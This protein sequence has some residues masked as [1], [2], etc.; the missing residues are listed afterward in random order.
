MDLKQK[1]I[2]FY[3][4][5]AQ[6]AAML[7]TAVRLK[8]GAIIVKNNSIS[9]F[10][11]NGTPAGWDNM[12]ETKEYMKIDAAGW[13]DPAEIEEMYP[14]KEY[15][16]AVESHRRYKLVTKQET[17]HAEMNAL[18]KLTKNGGGSDG[19]IMFVTHAPCI[20][21]AKAIYQ[22]G[23]KEVHYVHEYRETSGVDFLTTAGIKVQK[24]GDSE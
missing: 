9:S 7:S 19:A 5:V 14:L 22:S 1:F 24:Y 20:H 11:Y 23:I 12:C 4:K 17:I 10:G 15:D 8:V 21:C 2:D 13:L 6:D 18:M 3:V 16:P